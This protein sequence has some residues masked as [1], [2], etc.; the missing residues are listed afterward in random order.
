MENI[1]EKLNWFQK[2]MKFLFFPQIIAN[3]FNALTMD[4]KGYSL[5]KILACYGTYIAGELTK[6]WAVEANAIAFAI[7]WLVW[8]GILIGIYS[9]KDITDAFGKIRGIKP[10]EQEINP[11]QN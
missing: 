1:P 3:I 2:F 4:D 6:K 9:L 10:P 7:L 11:P 5:K 8:A